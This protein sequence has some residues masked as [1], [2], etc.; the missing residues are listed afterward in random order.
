[1]LAR[2]TG[3]RKCGYGWSVDAQP[4]LP[5]RRGGHGLRNG[6]R[7]SRRLRR[8]ATL[9]AEGV[10]IA[11]LF[12]AVAGEV[13]QVLDVSTVSLERYETEGATLVA[14]SFSAPA[15]RWAAG[16]LWTARACTLARLPGSLGSRGDV[17]VHIVLIHQ[18]GAGIH[19]HRNGRERVSAE[20]PLPSCASGA[21]KISSS[22]RSP[23]QPMVKASG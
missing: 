19:K 18:R 17:E 8:V 14:A 21:W 4:G 6:P 10:P 20:K 2:P 3:A 12:G 5:G 13:A 23:C 11:D 15:F 22:E 16:G 9:V 1:M 7:A